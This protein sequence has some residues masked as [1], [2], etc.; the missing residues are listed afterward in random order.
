[1]ASGNFIFKDGPSLDG[2]NEYVVPAL[3][4]KFVE[5]ED[6]IVFKGGYQSKLLFSVYAKHLNSPYN[7]IPSPPGLENAVKE[8]LG[9]IGKGIDERNKT[10]GMLSIHGFQIRS[11]ETVG[12]YQKD[13]AASM[14][15]PSIAQQYLLQSLGKEVEK[16]ANEIRGLLGQK[17]SDLV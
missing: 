13:K 1:M 10:E 16:V 7:C 4:E 11:C 6:R 12:V 14:L 15:F 3:K 9:N 17:L 2:F 5:V 8:I